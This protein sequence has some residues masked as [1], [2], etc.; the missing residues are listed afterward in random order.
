MFVQLYQQ[1]L[2]TNITN[3]WPYIIFCIP[4]LLILTLLVIRNIQ[5]L[6]Y[7]INLIKR[8]SDKNEEEIIKGI[9]YNGWRYKMLDEEISYS[10]MVIK[11]WKPLD[12]FYDLNKLLG[13]ERKENGTGKI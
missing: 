5:V 3:H 9:G 2:E 8:I 10:E 7:R 1:K 11:F 12:S 13:E 4:I 6:R